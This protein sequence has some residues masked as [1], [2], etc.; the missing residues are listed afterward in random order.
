[1]DRLSSK[2]IR[3]DT[4][5]AHDVRE[6]QSALGA[7]CWFG[8][9]RAVHRDGRTFVGWVSAAGEIVVACH[10]HTSGATRRAVLMA[11]FPVDDHNNPSLAIDPDGRVTVFWTGHADRIHTAMYYRRTTSPL[12]I[13]AWEPTRAYA[14]NTAGAKSF[15]YN[16]PVDLEAEG[17]RRYLFWRG[18][19]FN[20]TYAM[21][22]GDDM[23]TPPAS[24]VHVPG[25]R[26]YLKVV[27]NGVDRIDFAFTDGHPRNV[28][29]S[30]FHMYYRRGMLHRS[31]GTPI[32]P[33]GARR[34]ELPAIAPSS[35][36]CVYAAASGPKAWIHDIAV[37]G[38]GA[39]ALVFATFPGDPEH[40]RHRYSY[41]RYDGSA[42]QLS[43][44]G[45]AGDTI[46]EHGPDAAPAEPGYSGGLSI[47]HADPAVVLL[48]RKQPGQWHRIERRQTRDHGESWTGS[49]LTGG[50]EQAVRPVR[51]RGLAGD[52]AMSTLWLQGRYSVY[53]EVGTR[54][55]GTGADGRPVSLS[56]D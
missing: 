44:L 2:M 39:P 12:D 42:W 7:W 9:P 18:G 41:A 3:A 40:T 34:G 26:P 1:M 22:D 14:A 46:Y 24:L 11:D 52:G 27:G 50:A 10:D 47:D 5:P 51:P 55:M 8:D 35:A 19:D 30:I 37:D 32:G 6:P 36:T 17:N 56:G 16:S 20:P 45:D 43:D 48:A 15:T 23:W 13:G 53:T 38:D 54:V 4:L 33:M 29:T 49:V 31:D 25:Q 28:H 21:T